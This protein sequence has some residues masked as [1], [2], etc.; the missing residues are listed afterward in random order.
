MRDAIW[1]IRAAGFLRA[2]KSLPGTTGEESTFWSRFNFDANTKLYYADSHVRAANKRVMAGVTDVW[3]FDAHHDA[4]RSVEEVVKAVR[5]SCE[6][7]TVLYHILGIPVTSVFPQW[8]E[9]RTDSEPK[10]PMYVSVDTGAE[11]RPGFNRIFICRSS[12][13]TPSW[14]EDKFWEFID[15]CPVKTKINLDE[16]T[17]R[18]FNIADA[19]GW[20]KQD[21]EVIEM[22]EKRRDTKCS[23]IVTE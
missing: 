2:D 7:W 19:E 20:V 13:W 8:A 17:K 12:A 9:Y 22:A 3:N 1:T 18:Q 11:I 23:Q 14:L 4:Y 15:A 10:I 5:V 6:D 16:M 21:K